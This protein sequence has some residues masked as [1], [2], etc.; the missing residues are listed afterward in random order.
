M[1]CKEEENQG[2]KLAPMADGVVSSGF[3]PLEKVVKPT[4]WAGHL[5]VIK[6]RKLTMESEKND[7]SDFQQDNDKALKIYMSS[8]GS[9]VTNNIYTQRQWEVPSK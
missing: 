7:T 1:V 2:D 5:S 4:Y 6:I 8:P 3:E 9:A